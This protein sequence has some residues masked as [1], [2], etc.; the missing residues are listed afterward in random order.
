[1][2]V[3]PG[4]FVKLKPRCLA[5]VQLPGTPMDPFDSG[6][7]WSP[8]RIAPSAPPP[9]VY[10][11]PTRRQLAEARWKTC[12][13]PCGSPGSE[14][15]LCSMWRLELRRSFGGAQFLGEDD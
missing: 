4:T 6:D 13:F 10:S 5:A 3:L 11:E 12:R 8:W 1:M 7:S 9:G 14:S 2:E 15:E